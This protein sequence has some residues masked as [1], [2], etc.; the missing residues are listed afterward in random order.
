M[1][2]SQAI[3]V[4]EL[5]EP[6]SS[7]AR[8]STNPSSFAITLDPGTRSSRRALEWVVFAGSL[9]LHVALYLKVHNNVTPQVTRFVSS[10]V[11]IELAPP[12]IEEPKV[13]EPEPPPEPPPPADK[14]V[15]R[16]QS[17]APVAQAPVDLPDN[18][19]LPSS[20]EGLLEP[21]PP[22][23]GTP[24]PAPVLAP[25]PPP[26]PPPPAPVI[27]AKVGADF[28][29][30]P[31]LEYP[32]LARREEWEG[33]VILRAQVLPS[34]KVGTVSVQ[35]SSGHSVL[36]DAALSAAKTW[37]FVPATQGGNPV[38]GTVTFPVQFKL[39]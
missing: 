5:S 35:K 36:D 33:T 26:P 19:N 12:V 18:S 4:D 8:E 30:K 7:S 39:Q 29:R 24:G 25:P 38:A 2:E 21:T 31:G 34:G 3:E 16:V 27:Q 14:P 32:R 23:T 1:A 22:G 20:D 11:D 28:A 10:Q 9:A 6:T 13:K 17:Q 37:S 15:P